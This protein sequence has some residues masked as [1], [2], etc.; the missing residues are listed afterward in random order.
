MFPLIF[1]VRRTLFGH[2]TGC[3]WLIFVW[4]TR[5]AKDRDR[6]INHEKIHYRQQL[7]MLFI[8]HWML[9]GWYYF[10]SRLK[11]LDHHRAYMN[12]PFEREAYTHEGDP[13]Y[14]VTRAPFA[15]RKYAKSL[16]EGKYQK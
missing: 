2:Y 8:L 12:I 6:I 10:H 4:V 13:E 5:S 16:P 3:S 1:Y 15:W 14:L 11:G 7:E 9:Y